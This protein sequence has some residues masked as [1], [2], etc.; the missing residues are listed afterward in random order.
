MHI[1]P[2]E[3]QPLVALWDHIRIIVSWCWCKVR[4]RC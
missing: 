3:L 2:D 1:C 4:Y